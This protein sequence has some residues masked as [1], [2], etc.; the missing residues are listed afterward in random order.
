MLTVLAFLLA[1]DELPS[2]LD[3]DHSKSLNF[4][5]NLLGVLH[6]N[7][8]HGLLLRFINKL[9]TKVEKMYVHL[10]MVCFHS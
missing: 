4:R 10:S 3:V 7:E 9:F 8:I 2:K 5:E 6:L 1:N